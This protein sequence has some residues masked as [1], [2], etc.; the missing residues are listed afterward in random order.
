MASRWK[1][2][3]LALL[4]VLLVALGLVW[5]R[6][7]SR[8][9]SSASAARS[10]AVLNEITPAVVGSSGDAT[11]AIVQPVA[12]VLPHHL[13]AKQLMVRLVASLRRARPQT[14]V[15]I[16]PD[17]GNLGSTVF[18]TT[19]SDWRGPTGV[20]RTDRRVAE[21]LRQLPTVSVA[22]ELMGQEHSAL[23]PLPFL[24]AQ[25][26]KAQFVL[27]LVRG[28]DHRAA[29]RELSDALA[30]TLGQEDLVIASVDFSHYKNYP[31]AQAEDA[32]SIAALEKNNPDALA[33]IPVDSP[34]SLTVAVLYAQRRGMTGQTI[35]DHSNSALIL[36]DLA[37][38]STTSYVTLVWH[39][40]KGAP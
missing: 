18:T 23:T 35:L 11:P 19:L 25:F 38:V 13:V 17:H 40:G 15:V 22:E 21:A 8:P 31:T 9:P 16:G 37:L 3:N 36:G 10:S 12:A 6:G 4:G 33:T 5:A 1:F 34:A 28:G 32:V 26:P 30:R 14:I 24:A 39:R 27:L 2:V 7:G 20:F 29:V